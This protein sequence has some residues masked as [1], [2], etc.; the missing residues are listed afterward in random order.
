MANLTA[1]GA[2]LSRQGLSDRLAAWGRHHRF[3]FKDALLRLFD[4]PLAAITTWMVV[5][6][7]LALPIILY[8]LL[9]YAGTLRQDWD[10]S[11]R[12]S[13]YLDRDVAEDVAGNMTSRII[14]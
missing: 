14:K 2:S 7:A 12:I 3:V 13:L 9:N 8:L 10:G 5:A 1:S 11:P 4:T 6:I